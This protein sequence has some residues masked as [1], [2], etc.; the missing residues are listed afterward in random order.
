MPKGEGFTLIELMV[1]V[2]VLAVVLTAGV[3]SFR[4]IVRN[5]RL[6]SMANEFSATLNYARSEA[7][8]RG[9]RVSVRK[10]GTN[11][12]NGWQ[13]F[14]DNSGT[15]GTNDGTD[16][17]LRVHGALSQNYI[18][19][20]N[21]NFANFISFMANGTS[22]NMGTFALCDVSSGSNTPVRG[23]SRVLIVNAVGRVRMGIDSNSNGIPETNDGTTVTDLSDCT[24]P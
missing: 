21:N 19:R 17:T 20:G 14:T 6:S 18:L 9:I 12:E 3:P 2:A 24:S 22:N 16:V 11:W 8:K 13:V 7:I 10:S 1:A 5:N 23:T 4:D 15:A